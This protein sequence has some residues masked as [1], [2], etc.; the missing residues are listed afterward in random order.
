MLPDRISLHKLQD[1]R[2]LDRDVFVA[3]VYQSQGVAIARD[4]F[5]IAVP[6][7]GFLFAQLPDARRRGHYPFDFVGR[8]CALYL[9]DLHQLGKRRG[10]LFQKKAL[11]LVLVYLGDQTE[12]FA[13]PL[14]IP[15][16]SVIKTPHV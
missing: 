4:L 3:F 1:I 13:V 11:A 14:D 16:F 7:R 15:Q 2:R 5:F 9:G 12:H 10:L 6:R 8:L